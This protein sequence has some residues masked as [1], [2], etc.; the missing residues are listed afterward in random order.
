MSKYITF[1]TRRLLQE[2]NLLS[3]FEVITAYHKDIRYIDVYLNGPSESPYY[4]F[5]FKV[6]I[7]LGELFPFKPINITFDSKIKHINIINGLICPN[8]VIHFDPTESSLADMLNS[9]LD[10]LLKPNLQ[11]PLDLQLLTLYLENKQTYNDCIKEH[12]KQYAL[13]C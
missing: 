4:G 2:F 10:L 8:C 11:Y 12:C 6:V 3:N 13:T 5:K 7:D 1:K 9:I